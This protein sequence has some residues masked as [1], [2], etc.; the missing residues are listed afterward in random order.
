MDA[1][2]RNISP[3]ALL[4][5]NALDGNTWMAF[6]PAFGVMMLGAAGLFRSS[7]GRQRWL[8]W[9]ALVLGIALFFPFADFIA[10]L[11]TLIWIVVTSAT[12][13]RGA[14]RVEHAV[15]AH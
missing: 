11:G 3:T 15:L 14:R 2:D 12:M 10:L 8:G 1:G 5:L 6:N 7:A 13:A 4:A 9:V